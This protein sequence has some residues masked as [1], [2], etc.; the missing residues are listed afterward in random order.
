MLTLRQEMNPVDRLRTNLAAQT[1]AAQEMDALLTR[2]RER[3]GARDWPAVQGIAS[4][5]SAVATRLQNLMRE[6][7]AATGDA[8]G[9]RLAALGLKD[10]WD[11]LLDRARRL[12][13]ANRESR[14]LLDR[15]HARASAALQM[16][17]RGTVTP[18]YSRHGMARF[19]GLRQKL[20]AA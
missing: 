10:E 8:P 18:T 7:L 5:K 3:I 6:L 11:A 16:L 2:E 13:D 9:T 1:V 15:H 20:A 19:G 14:V 17:N 12:Q 4:E